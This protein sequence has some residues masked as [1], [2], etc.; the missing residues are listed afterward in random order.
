M[1]QRF[2]SNRSDDVKRVA[3]VQPKKIWWSYSDNGEGD[4]FEEK[5][6]ANGIRRSSE[7]AL[8]EAITH[9]R[10]RA[11][12]SATS[13]IVGSRKSPANQERDAQRLE[14]RAICPK[15]VDEL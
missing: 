8:P 13:H 12:R 4:A 15:T 3:N 11:G 9:D 2:I 7:V 1:N 14:E 5:R 6:S 10:D